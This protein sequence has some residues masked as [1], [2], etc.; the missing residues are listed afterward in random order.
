[1]GEKW[2]AESVE[3]L[4]VSWVVLLE[5]KLVV[6]LGAYLAEKWADQSAWVWEQPWAWRLG[7]PLELQMELELE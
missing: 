5:M 4:V 2:V 6:R 1:M 7:S 3:M